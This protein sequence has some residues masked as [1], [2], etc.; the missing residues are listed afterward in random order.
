MNNS[1]AAFS[2]HLA[3]NPDA[4]ELPPPSRDFAGERKMLFVLLAASVLLPLICLAGYGYYDFQRRFADA[5][6]DSERSVRVAEEQA[7]KVM[8][9]NAELV[10]RIEEVL[11]DTPGTEVH[12]DEAPL[13]RRLGAIAGGFPQV[14]AISIFGESGSLLVSSRFFPVP[15]INVSQREDFLAARHLSPEQYF[16]QP[17][18]AS[19]SGASVFNI[20]KARTA[21]DGTFLGTVSIALRRDYFIGFYQKLMQYD[22]GTFV[23]LYR[24]D[25]T[26]LASYPKREVAGGNLT[27]GALSD[28]F[29]RKELNGEL[30]TDR[31]A[32]HEQ[33]VVVYRRVGDYPLFVA[34]G[35]LSSQLL[36]GWLRHLLFLSTLAAIPVSAIWALLAF[37]LRQLSAEERAWTSWRGEIA[38][39]LEAEASGRHLQKMSALGNLVSNVAH[40]FNNYA[41]AVTTNMAIARAKGLRDLE[42]EVSAV[43]RATR[44][45]EALVRT[46]M[47]ATRKQPA[48]LTVVNLADAMPDLGPV[49]RAAV[50]DSIEVTVDAPADVW[51]VR[52]DAAELEMA[53][54]NI[55]LNARD[56]MP[57]G[58]KLMLR[59][60]NIEVA[61]GTIEVLA[62]EYVLITASDNG[63]GMTP[64]VA[65]HAFEPLF[66]TK[67][68]TTAA[69]LGLTQVQ[70][71]CE[72]SGGVAKIISS[73]GA[74][75][76]LCLYL[77]RC[78]S[79][80]LPAADP[81]G[82]VSDPAMSG[83]HPVLLVEDN[84]DVAAGLIAVLEL[85]GHQVT[86]LGNADD[87]LLVLQAGK[88]FKLVLS[89]IQ[90]PGESNGVD[91]AEWMKVNR[92]GQPVALMTGYA[93]ELERARRTG[94]PIFVKPFNVHELVPFMS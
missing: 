75:S 11:D 32:D 30:R 48:K 19:V 2:P 91:L 22:D 66:T 59:A 64:S 83:Q 79:R 44:N 56:A 50:G 29:A 31:F 8:D 6:A 33:H 70:A 89:D 78:P 24:R 14:A 72:L 1:P 15:P 16:S 69:G 76:T 73:P 77:P 13:H 39:R 71:F 58:G 23:G 18:A 49:A 38:R 5:V 3:D 26:L 40:E 88:E 34:S 36:A 20:V 35:F 87:A 17:M 7:L 46:L 12:N 61:S 37:S 54:L 67:H 45:V 90:M 28:A 82:V 81:V 62:G 43:E 86:H 4:D 84:P 47:G 41:M 55:A 68:K 51:S 25:G 42:D 60:Q 53:V 65:E 85:M 94:V 92:P 27:S 52:C 21:S 74:G 63:T 57:L 10:S 9:L 93:D 80:E